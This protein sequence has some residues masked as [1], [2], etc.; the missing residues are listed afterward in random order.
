MVVTDSTG[1]EYESVGD[2]WK[3]E[4]DE[5]SVAQEKSD[6]EA[7]KKL[8]G[9]RIGSERN[10]YDGSLQYWEKKPA[11]VEGVLE[12]YGKYHEMESNYSKQVLQN[13]LKMLP[14]K[15]RA[16][17]A[18]AG[19]G[20]ITKSILKDVFA[21]IDLQDSSQEQLEGAKQNVPFVKK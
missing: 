13:H 11:T 7:Q 14:S 5:T 8:K 17:E 2:M 19:I 12:G 4:L 3:K 10:W 16:L 15:K 6:E 18:G 20:R 21:E 9:E 1:N